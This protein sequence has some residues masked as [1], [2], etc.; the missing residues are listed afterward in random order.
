MKQKPSALDKM[1]SNVECTLFVFLDAAVMK[2]TSPASQISDIDV[3]DDVIEDG[4]QKGDEA[5]GTDM[6]EEEEWTEVR[7]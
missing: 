3:M 4:V 1:L 5:K 6:A 7:V 2:D